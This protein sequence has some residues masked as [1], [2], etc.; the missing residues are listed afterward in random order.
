M[1][2]ASLKQAA[3]ARAVDG[4]RSGMRL[5]L[6][7]G[8]TAAHVVR[9]L[10]RRLRDGRLSGVVGVATSEATER[11]AHAE[12]VPV[13][14]L[15]A[16]PLAL[17]I[18]G[19]DE[20]DPRLDLVKGRGGALLREKLVALQSHE[21]LVVVDATKLVPRLGTRMPVPVEVVPFGHLATLARL[22]ATGGVPTLRTD[23][24]NLLVDVRFA[25]VDDAA[26]L[27]ARLKLVPGVVETGLFVGLAT[28]VL[29]AHRDGVRELTRELARADPRRG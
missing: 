2:I 23:G 26:A 10:G 20:V 18:D 11:L 6:G 16:R 15:D 28:R 12:G 22:A 9:E 14:L 24:G 17:T 8:S 7:S 5:G 13:E 25:A 3:A 4:V 29:V 1:D 21:L 27:A 19:A